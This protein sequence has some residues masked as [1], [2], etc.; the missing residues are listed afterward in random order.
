MFLFYGKLGKWYCNILRLMFIRFILCLR[1]R[2]WYS[3]WR[4]IGLPVW[5]AV[6]TVH[7]QTMLDMEIF[8][9]G[10]IGCQLSH[11]SL[12]GLCNS[13]RLP[14]LWE[15]IVLQ[16]PRFELDKEGSGWGFNCS[17]WCLE[18]IFSSSNGQNSTT[19]TAHHLE[20][21]TK[22]KE[23]PIVHATTWDC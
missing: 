17:S 19:L 9:M 10:N 1:F 23:F 6:L 22:C 12:P 18:L 15:E 16:P 4:L 3:I 21:T 14:F 13:H 2:Q 5:T 7:C 20:M 11:S 8:S